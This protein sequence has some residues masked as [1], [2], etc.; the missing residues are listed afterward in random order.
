MTNTFATYENTEYRITTQYPYNWE[1]IDYPRIGL[2]TVGSDLIV[3]FEAPVVNAS[4][5]WREHLMIQ[6]SFKI[7]DDFVNQ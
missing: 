6:D 2:S 4:D 5:H 3:N 1:K 7:V